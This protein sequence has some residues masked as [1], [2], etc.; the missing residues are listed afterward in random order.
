MDLNLSGK[1]A[2]ITGGSKGIGLEIV[3]TLLAEGMNVVSGSRRLTPELSAT[4]AVHV[5]VDLTTPDGPAERESVV[6]AL[7][8]FRP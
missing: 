6:V 4:Q 5:A 8:T 7:V 2:V 1:T 3:R